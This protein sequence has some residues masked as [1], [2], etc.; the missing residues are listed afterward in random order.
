MVSATD[1]QHLT[2]YELDEAVDAYEEDRTEESVGFDLFYDGSTVNPWEQGPHEIV[3]LYFNDDRYG[4]YYVPVTYAERIEEGIRSTPLGDPMGG[5]GGDSLEE[6]GAT[7][8]VGQG[9][10]IEGVEFDLLWYD[11]N[12]GDEDERVIA[13]AD[14]GSDEN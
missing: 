12:G 14:F 4:D 1:I 3:R 9:V 13:A 8:R 6:E 2:E 11:E 10:T 5:E 7:T